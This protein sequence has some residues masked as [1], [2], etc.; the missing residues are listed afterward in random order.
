M[1]RLTCAL[2]VLC[3]A[4]AWSSG[5]A[6]Q[7]SS[8]R[9]SGLV[10]VEYGGGASEPGFW[11]TRRTDEATLQ[12]TNWTRVN[13]SVRPERITGSTLGKT[14]SLAR[15]YF[16]GNTIANL[17]G[18]DPTFGSRTLALT[19][20]SVQ[21]APPRP[22]APAPRGPASYMPQIPGTTDSPPPAPID[23]PDD[24]WLLR[25][26]GTIIRPQRKTPVAEDQQYCGEGRCEQAYVYGFA[27]SAAT[28]AVA[29]VF[30]SGGTVTTR[31][32]EPLAGLQQ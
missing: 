10:H 21:S 25:Q 8:A 5:A 15:P 3:A 18:L 30:S 24:V 32:L 16:I 20:G 6:A 23:L 26:D 22:P 17:R 28:E 19:N 1:Q 13:A 14:E 12:F 2:F 4:T 29:V 11:W 7:D 31:E 9:E 27:P